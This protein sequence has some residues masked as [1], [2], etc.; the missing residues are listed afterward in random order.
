MSLFAAASAIAD[1][2]TSLSAFTGVGAGTFVAI[3]IWM[4]LRGHLVPGKERD[5][6]RSLAQE[7]AQQN[8]ALLRGMDTTNA[9]LRSL[10]GVPEQARGRDSP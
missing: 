6:W 8:S 7:L 2:V 3:T 10:P 5:Y 1:D 9:A 4:I